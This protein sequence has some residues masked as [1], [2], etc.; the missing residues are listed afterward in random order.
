MVSVWTVSSAAQT[1]KSRL[2][3]ALEAELAQFPAR[4]GIYLKHLKTGEEAAVRADESFNS[5]SVIKVPI[6]V[7]AFQLA[8]E[9][10]LNLNERVTLTRADLRD[11]TG[12]F[13]LADLGLAPTVRDLIQQM[14]ITSDNTATDQMTTKVGGVDALNAWL[15]KSGYRMRML[16]RG[17]E[18]RRKLLARL[19]PRL[20]GITAEETTGLQYAMTENPL[21]EHY[22]PVFTGERATWLDVV[23]NPANR[24]T[25]VENQRKLMVEDRNYWLGDISAREI[26]RMLEG[27]ERETLA[28]PASSAAMRTFLRRQLAGSRRLPHFVDV[29]VAHKTGDSGNIANDVGIIYAR[30]GPIVIAV[31][32]NGITGSYAEAEDR[33]GRIAKLV[34]DHFDSGATTPGTTAVQSPARKRAIQPAGYK[35][36]PSPLTPAILVGD[37]LYLSGSTGGDP[38][39]G[40][41]VTG[42]F[43][44]EMRQIMTNVQTVLA[45]A[46]MGLADVVSVTAYLADMSD[47][48]RFNEIYKEYFTST[49]LPTRSTVAVKELA[50][51]AR[52][53]LTMTAVRPQ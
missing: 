15:E 22:L 10:R 8:E 11:G 12:V 7:R 36:T 53:E 26:A 3:L 16:N 50:R 47:F 44:P 39:T 29:P 31:L 43:E 48:A 34:V 5:Q 1:S 9:R 46:G 14:I 28:S 32:A 52:L 40:Q 38:V 17:H 19:D 45:A 37:T 18:Y 33:I 2:T 13:Q 4:T 35:P 49:P 6:M 30:S 21:F 24:R 41:L 42:G 25:H 23:R 27:I 20:A 51:G